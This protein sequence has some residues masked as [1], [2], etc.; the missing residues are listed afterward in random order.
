MLTQ[1]WGPCASKQQ[2]EQEEKELHSTSKTRLQLH[3][4]LLGLKDAFLQQGA[5]GN[6]L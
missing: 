2:G 6:N 1:Y 3:A 4:F 5:I